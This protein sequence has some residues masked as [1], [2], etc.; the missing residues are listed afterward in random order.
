VPLQVE[1]VSAEE[2]LFSGESNFVAARTVEGD[3]GILPGHTPVLAR[4]V[5]YD[6]RVQTPDGERTFP[7][8]GGFMTVKDDRVIILA[9]E[10]EE[11]APAAD[12]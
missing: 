6:V 5:E 12:R 9:E 11:S 10:K 4:L 1:V 2:E 3:I 7:I 8:A